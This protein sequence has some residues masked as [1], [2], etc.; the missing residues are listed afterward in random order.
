MTSKT[1]Y[2]VRHQCNNTRKCGVRFRLKK[3]HREYAKPKRCPICSSS[4]NNI[5]K[6]RRKELAKQ[7]TCYCLAYPFPHKAGSL[8]MCDENTLFKQDIPPTQAEWDDY[9]SCLKTPRSEGT[10]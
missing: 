7:D 6:S 8:R 4:I 3:D 1:R 2:S 5:E 9:E 10:C